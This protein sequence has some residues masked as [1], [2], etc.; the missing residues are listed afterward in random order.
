LLRNFFDERWQLFE[1]GQKN[2][3][4][5][6]ISGKKRNKWTPLILYRFHEGFCL[7]GFVQRPI[8]IFQ[9]KK[10]TLLKEERWACSCMMDLDLYA[11]GKE[12]SYYQVAR[13]GLIGAFTPELSLVCTSF[14]I[15]FGFSFSCL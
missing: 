5:T 13:A 11:D 15:E 3:F 12:K 1:R 8:F 6:P 2:R 4:E 14:Y 9:K 10:K 7:V